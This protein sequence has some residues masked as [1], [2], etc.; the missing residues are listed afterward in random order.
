MYLWVTSKKIQ[1][2]QI[3]LNYMVNCGR[4][5]RPICPIFNTALPSRIDNGKFENDILIYARDTYMKRRVGRHSY[6][7]SK[8]AIHSKTSL[9]LLQTFWQTKYTF[10]NGYK[11]RIEEMYN[12]NSLKQ[13]AVES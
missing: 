12:N 7:D 5:V 10:T 3:F 2:K 9:W 1:Q 4:V 11:K 6:I 13:A 8:F